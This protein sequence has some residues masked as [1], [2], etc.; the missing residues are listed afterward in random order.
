MALQRDTPTDL[1][2][3]TRFRYVQPMEQTKRCPRCQ[4]TLNLDSFDY[5][6]AARTRIQSYCRECAKDSWRDWYR[7]PKNRE[8]HLALVAARRSARIARHKR[9]LAE[10][11]SAPCADCGQRF[12]PEA[13]DFDHIGDKRDNISRL[14]ASVG[15]TALLDELAKCEVVCA[16]CHRVRTAERIRNR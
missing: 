4:R 3:V 5:R 8:H 16:N 7:V 12:P 14:L 6:D 10:L 1:K 13:M 15:D 9:L 2:A 11:K